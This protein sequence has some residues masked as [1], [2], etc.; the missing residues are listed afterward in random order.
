MNQETNS[1]NKSGPIWE[2]MA[3]NT[4]VIRCRLFAIAFA[5]TF[6][7]LGLVIVLLPKRYESQMKLLVKNE[8]QDVVVSPERN[9]STIH[10]NELTETQVN[11]EIELIRSMDVLRQVALKS[12]LA[13]ESGTVIAA[14]APSPIAL[15]N[16][17]RSLE[18]QLD[19]SPVK[20]SNIIEIS[21][22]ANAP[23]VAANVLNRL[24]ETYLEAHL[25]VHGASGTYTFFAGQA[26]AYHEALNKAEDELGALRNRFT[27]LIM[28]DAQA[29]LIQ[30]A[31]D[32][33]AALEDLDTQISEY[34]KRVNQGKTQ[35][36]GMAPRVTSQVRTVPH[37]QLVQQLSE[38]ITQ[39]KNR[40]TELLTKFKPDDRLVLEVDT[41]IIETTAALEKA[42]EQSSVETQTDLNAVRQD[43][44]KSFVTADVTLAGLKARRAR[45]AQIVSAYREKMHTLA[46]ATIQHDQLV[47]TVKEDEENYLL[48]SRKMEEARIEQALDQQRI[49]NVAV[50]QAPTVPVTPASPRIKLDLV[51]AALLAALV[52]F[53]TVIFARTFAPAA[54]ISPGPDCL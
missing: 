28:P 24:V 26:A 1:H 4:V 37:S 52:A 21:Y 48:Y 12:G 14:G 11:S 18:R 27:V 34:E 43:A 6:V 30:R 40:R 23:E 20:K 33:E 5:I 42:T 51:L 41:E 50:I 38:T 17:V 45:L 46:D 3:I 39:L 49:A 13:H 9:I 32:A 7:L 16:A 2:Q 15:A 25:K 19:I 31:I 22:Q 8:R 53:V 10:T 36:S 29:P 54:V 47:R 44:E 35:I